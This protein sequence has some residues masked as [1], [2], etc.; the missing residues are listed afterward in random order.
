MTKK[1]EKVDFDLSQLSLKELIAT[2]QDIAT[3]L[4]FL[5]S[6]K[7]AEKKKEEK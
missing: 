1:P 2:Y 5:E 4:D 7:I 6:K 3:F